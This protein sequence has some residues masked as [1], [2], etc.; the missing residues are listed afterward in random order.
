MPLVSPDLNKAPSCHRP[1]FLKKAAIIAIG[2]IDESGSGWIAN[3]QSAA[4]VRFLLL[5]LHSG[6]S[7]PG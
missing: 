3:G 1:G 2:H 4:N 6:L 7:A 5:P